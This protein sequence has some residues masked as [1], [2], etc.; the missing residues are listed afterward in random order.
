[1]QVD[2]I[3]NLQHDLCALNLILLCRINSK[4]FGKQFHKIC[5]GN[6][7]SKGKEL[8]SLAGSEIRN[9]QLN[10]QGYSSLRYG[11]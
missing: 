11:N 4:G 8:T 7:I 5:T 6:W 2:V 3:M 9:M 1:M 10:V